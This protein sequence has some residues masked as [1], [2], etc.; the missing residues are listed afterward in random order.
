MSQ[1]RRWVLCPAQ[2]SFSFGCQSGKSPNPGQ[3]VVAVAKS[4]GTFYKKQH[5][6]ATIGTGIIHLLLCLYSSQ[7]NKSKQ[8]R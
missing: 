2:G 7:G 5:G 3:D 4:I 1:I 6:I 8:K